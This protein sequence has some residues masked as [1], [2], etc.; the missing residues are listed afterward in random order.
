M[1]K[2]RTTYRGYSGA[3]I[4]ARTSFPSTLAD[5]VVAGSN[6]SY[7]NLDVSELCDLLST[8]DTD[9][10]SVFGTNVVNKYSC[11]SAFTIGVS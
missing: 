5:I 1:A 7:T 3:T 6:I 8:L 9:I 10:G 4:K 2:V 11:F